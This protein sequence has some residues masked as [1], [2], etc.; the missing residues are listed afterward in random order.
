MHLSLM[1][2]AINLSSKLLTLKAIQMSKNMANRIRSDMWQTLFA[3]QTQTVPTLQGRLRAM[4][5]R[6]ILDGFLSPGAVL[7]SSR[8]MAIILSISRNTVTQAYLHLV[9]HGYLVAL[10]RSGFVVQERGPLHLNP[11]TKPQISLATPSWNERIARPLTGLRNIVKPA[12]WQRYPYPFLY[13][14]FDSSLFPIR[15]WRECST[16]ALRATAVRD[17]A[18]DRMDQDDSALLEQLQQRILPTRG[19]WASRDEILITMGAQ[20]ANYILAEILVSA[21]TVLGLEDPGYP[22]VRNIF[23]TRGARVQSLPVGPQGISLQAPFGDCDYVY[24]TPSH[25]CP[26]TV[27]MPPEK[28]RLLLQ[29]AIA[30]NVVII[31]D[32]Y[33][34]ELNFVGKPSA[35]IKSLDPSGH[36]IYVG[37]LSKTIAPGLRVGFMVAD[38][39]LIRE[40]RAARRLM[41]RHPPINNERTLALFLGMGHHNILMRKLTR[42]YQERV[43]QLTTSLAKYLP[44]WQVT[45]PQGGSALWVRGSKG[46]N[47]D[48]I[49]DEAKKVG[50]LLEAGSIFFA[51]PSDKQATRYARMGIASIAK[52]KIH[53]G[54]AALASIV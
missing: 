54:V 4:L 27:T 24:V 37:S 49:V 30:K 23:E 44:D 35:A 31:E 7:P 19:I 25:Q 51:D 47:M 29:E 26:T 38:R 2:C 17:W 52:E 39:A 36:V 28:R 46:L 12:D 40:A 6:G 1:W 20:Q 21:Q 11:I 41:M 15:A 32:D 8:E 34:S 45:V 5:V 18:S 43:E 33:D 14:Q 22:D 42:V 50:V 3:K 16:N 53:E 9:D 13:G 10:P 48:S